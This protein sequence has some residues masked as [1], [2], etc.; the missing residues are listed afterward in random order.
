MKKRLLK[1][2]LFGSTIVL[3]TM[4][5]CDKND[6]P[7]DNTDGAS[8]PDN[9]P[10]QYVTL[11]AAFPDDEGTAGN[12]G[13]LAYALTLEE[14][15][16]DSKEIDIWTD[17][18]SLRSQRTARV[19]GSINGNFL[20]NIQYTGPNGGIFNK[21]RVSGGKNFE[22]TNEE[23][24]V[25][26]IL[27]AAPRWVK[28]AE[29][30]GVGVNISGASAPID[31]EKAEAGTQTYEY[32][33]GTASI[34]IIDLDDPRVPNTT[35]FEFPLTQAEKEAGYS[36]G[37]LDVPIIRG[38]KIFIG[39]AVSKVDPTNL[40]RTVNSE[41]QAVTWSWGNDAGNIKGTAT[42][43]IDYPSLANPKLIWSTQSNYGNNSYRTM[44][45]YIGDDGHIYQSTGV[46]TTSHPHIL[47]IDKNTNDYDNTYLFDLSQALGTSNLTGIRAWRY[48]K[49][50]IGI[51]LYTETG[52][53][54][55]YVALVDLNAKTATKL[56]TENQTDVGFSGLSA[57][58]N[59][60]KA[61]QGSLTQFQNI[62]LAGD[63]VYVPLTPNG[64]DGNLYIVN[65]KNKTI[66][67]GIK[68]KGQTGSF[69][70]GA[71]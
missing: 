54:G 70:L 19:Q 52:V 31:P 10:R 58:Q 11:T 56:A 71:Y 48:I 20:Y 12:G 13:T 24:N 42:L 30:V 62:G 8:G 6:G 67:K 49:D 18:Y 37:R 61:L 50:G 2:L 60:G 27:G 25:S 14:A 22:D 39:C 15:S 44:T 36:V 26:G 1:S 43:V 40:V 32:T 38:N 33:R 23:L 7:G 28:A 57:A 16:D 9:S 46:N 51:V 53:A 4:V 29:G 63:Y 35:E 69:Y 45:Q 65:W 47:R 55:G 59:G 41:T 3:G 21:Y 68:L 66:A 64:K 17:G 34:A 5:S